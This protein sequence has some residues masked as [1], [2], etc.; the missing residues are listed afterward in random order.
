MQTLAPQIQDVWVGASSVTPGQPMLMQPP[1]QTIDIEGV[2]WGDSD[3][4]TP[5]GVEAFITSTGPLGTPQN[6]PAQIEYSDGQ[7]AYNRHF[8]ASWPGYGVV[9]EGQVV[10]VRQLSPGSLSTVLSPLNVRQ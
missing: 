3:A 6:V 5:I 4:Q 7:P 1:G 10:T 2:A 9:G 8:T